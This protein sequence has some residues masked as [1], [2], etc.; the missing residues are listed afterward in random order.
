MVGIPCVQKLSLRAT[1]TPANGP[2]SSPAATLRI[3]LGGGRPGF[4]ARHEVE[5]VDVAIA[6]VDAAEVLLDDVQ[7][8]PL[9]RPNGRGDPDRATA[10]PIARGLRPRTPSPPARWRSPA[11]A[12][13]P[14][15]APPRG[16]RDAE[17]AVLGGRGLR[18]DLV[19]VE[20]R[21]HL[22]GPEDVAQLVGVGGR[23]D[24]VDVER[25]DVLGVLEHRRELAGEGVELALVLVASSSTAATSSRVRWGPSPPIVGAPTAQLAAETALAAGTAASALTAASYDAVA[26]AVN[27]RKRS[28]TRSLS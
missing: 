15:T 1:G 6:L 7:R 8:R 24:V 27:S 13:R 26:L 28:V 12:V 22:V 21:A 5:G 18:Q 4:V 25:L 11:G 10:P 23:L 3:D 20:R 16:S 9:P 2:G 17:A 19:A 14:L